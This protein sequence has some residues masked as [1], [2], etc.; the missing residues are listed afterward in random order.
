MIIFVGGFPGGIQCPSGIVGVVC[1]G[2]TDCNGTLD[3]GEDEQNCSMLILTYTV[4][5][6]RQKSW[7]LRAYYKNLYM[8]LSQVLLQTAGTLYNSPRYCKMS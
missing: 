4:D 5:Q 2:A 8:S 7:F 1:D 3:N 6:Q